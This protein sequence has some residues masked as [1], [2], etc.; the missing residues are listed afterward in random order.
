MTL[1]F[2]PDEAAAR[3]ATSTYLIAWQGWYREWIRPGWLAAPRRTERFVPG[4]AAV[5]AALRSWTSQKDAFESAF[6]STSIP[7]R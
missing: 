3:N 5:L 2:H 7:V 6:Y 4:D 1:V